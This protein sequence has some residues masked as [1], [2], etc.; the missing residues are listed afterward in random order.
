MIRVII[1]RDIKEASLTD[2]LTLI[3][4][5]R[6]QANSN[7][8]FIAGELLQSKDNPCHAVIISSW[9][10]YE[11]WEI[12]SKSDIRLKVLDE[13]RPLLKNDEKVTVLENSQLLS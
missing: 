5:A 11:S 4:K 9:D 1:E 10:S 12:W 3:R 6:K 2:Y 7:D 13:M 8:G